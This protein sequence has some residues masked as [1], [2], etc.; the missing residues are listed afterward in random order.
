[1]HLLAYVKLKVTVTPMVR[2][3]YP[4]R[5]KKDDGV[6][7]S[8]TLLEIT[9]GGA[10]HYQSKIGALM[11][12]AN[13]WVRVAVLATGTCILASSI[14]GPGY[15]QQK[16]SSLQTSAKQASAGA[17]AQS[18]FSKGQT[19]LQTGDLDEAEAEFRKVLALDP[20]AAPAYSN[21]GVVAMRRRDWDGALKLLE[22][23]EKLDPKMT[24]VRLNVGLVQ[25]RR[26]DYG[27]AIAP[28]ASVLRD[29]PEAQ[30][31]RYLLGLC[32]VFT[33]NY[34][35]A[36]DTL[37]P[38][39]PSM[40]GNVVYLYV[41]DIA[42]RGTQ[43]NQLDEKALRRMLEIGTDTPEFRLIMGKAYIFRGEF[44][45]AV[46][47]LEKAVASNP[48][49]AFVHMNLGIA[50]MRLGENEIAEAEFKKEIAAEP[51]LADSYEQLGQLYLQEQ[52]NA[53]AEKMFQAALQRNPKLARIYV[54][55]AK[56]QFEEQKNAEALKSIDAALRA[57]PDVYSGHYWRARILAR[58]GRGTEAKAEFAAAKKILESGLDKDRKIIEDNSMPNPELNGASE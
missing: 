35:N 16:A 33:R 29:Q 45:E 48:D 52:R 8:H 13:E 39:W 42:A 54:G 12:K 58:L 1:V 6:P 28:F 11:A 2:A 57:E 21:L 15:G 31:P 51:D 27:R 46:A 20:G 3:G 17:Q 30:Q 44:H 18:A 43:N 50:H 10:G 24:G 55:L 56:L 26:G 22:K 32:Y 36:I 14:S 47:E 23:A 41:L 19:A 38:L 40:S 5:E 49:L 37:L 9:Q 7:Y 25:Y 53:E 4:G 34:Q